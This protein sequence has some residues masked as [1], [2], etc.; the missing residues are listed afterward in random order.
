MKRWEPVDILVGLLVFALAFS[1]IVWEILP[2]IT[3]EKATDIQSKTAA[4]LISSL[5]SIVSVYIGTKVR[6]NN[7][8]R[9]SHNND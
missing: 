5:I 6:D 4:G 7:G 1:L 9:N 8:D 3:G 2:I